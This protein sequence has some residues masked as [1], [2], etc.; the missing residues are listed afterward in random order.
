MSRWQ[1][2]KSKMG[3]LEEE[4]QAKLALAANFER[5][6]QALRLKMV[7]MER[8]LAARDD[9]M[10]VLAAESRRGSEPDGSS[11][12][13][14]IATLCS[15]YCKLVQ[16]AS[17][18]LVQLSEA[19]V[20]GN[21]LQH[22]LVVEE[23]TKLMG[24]P[25]ASKITSSL[26]LHPGLPF[27]LL[28]MRMDMPLVPAEPPDAALWDR[29][30]HEIK[31]SPQQVQ[32]LSATWQLKHEKSLKISSE[33]EA[34]SSMMTEAV[35]NH[36]SVQLM[37][38]HQRLSAALLKEHT[39]YRSCSFIV[40]QVLDQVQVCKAIVHSFPYF[41]DLHEIVSR[42]TEG[43]GQA[44]GSSSGARPSPDPACEGL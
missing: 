43:Q 30:A 32:E 20:A 6:N 8:A 1:R 36:R 26:V 3:S 12:S 16:R 11:R 41:P 35:N 19:Q 44:S 38:A 22:Q 31:P 28:A 7:A 24:S 15:D 13:D 9:Q 27:H 33:M 42:L 23:M 5:E 29:V 25:E 14:D 34:L 18:L 40:R 17:G 4:A 37:E 10:K 39:S 21:V 2:D